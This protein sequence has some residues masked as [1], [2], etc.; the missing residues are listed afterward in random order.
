VVDGTDTRVVQGWSRILAPGETV[1]VLVDVFA[2][3]ASVTNG[4]KALKQLADSDVTTLV[5]TG[6]TVGPLV[7]HDTTLVDTENIPGEPSNAIR[8]FTDGSFTTPTPWGVIGRNLFLR[9]DAAACDADPAVAE[10]RTVLI[11]GANGESEQATA[12]ETGPNTGIFVVAPLPIHAPPVVA[13]DGILE[14]NPND[15]FQVEL[16]G[17]GQTIATV[18]TLMN[19]ASV[20][21]DS[22][23]NDPIANATVRLVAATGGS[24]GTTAVSLP[25]GQSNPATTG[26]DGRFAFN[27]PAGDYCLVVVPP[28]GWAF[29]SKIAYTQLPAGRN[30]NVTGLTAGGSYGNS[31]HVG[32]DGTVVVDVPL[33]LTAQSGLFVQKD[34]SKATAEVGDFV[35]YTVGVRNG[36]GNALNRADVTLTDNFPA[37]FAYVAG[38]ARR[39]GAPLADPVKGAGA[40]ITFDIGHLDA[41]ALATITYRAR[42]APAA[43]KGDGTNRAQAFYTVAGVTTASNVAAAKVQ[44]EGGVFSDKGF[45]LGKIFLDCNANGLQDKGEEG[46]PGVRILLEDGTYAITDGEGKFSF[47]GIDARTHVVKAD[48]VTLPRGASLEVLSARNLGD[49]N[50]RIVD[51]KSGEM[52]R[53]DFAIAGCDEAVRGEV[54]GRRAAAAR[55]DDLAGLAGAQLTTERQVITDVKALPASGVVERTPAAT[56]PGAAPNA[57]PGVTAPYLSVAPASRIGDTLPTPAP[58][59]PVSRSTPPPAEPLE[60]LVEGFAD[61]HLA[62]VG[63]ED[64][65]TLA[66]AQSNIRV[67]GTAGTTFRLVVNDEA[68]PGSAVGKR[69]VLAAK[70]V[71]AW[72]FVGIDLRAGDNTIT[73]VQI[74]SFGNERGTATIHVK[75]PGH[76]GKIAIDVPAA[77]AIADGKTPVKVVVR[78]ADENGVPVTVR[79]PVTLESARGRWLSQDLDTKAPGLQQFIENGRGEFE[80]VPTLEPGENMVY[81]SSGRLKAQARLDFLPEMRDMVATGVIE[82]IINAR[83]IN[84]RALQPATASDAFEQELRHLSRE[85]NAGKADGGVR[86]AF[87]LK[88]KIKGDYLLTAAYDSDKDTRERLFRDIQPDEFYPVYGDSAVR[89]FDAQSTSKLYVRVDKGRSYLLWGDFSTTAASETRKL[90]NYTRS[91]TGLKEHYENSRLSVNAFASRDTTRQVIE[92]QRANGTS[93]PFQLS[94]SGS[95]VNSETI[96]VV[97][98]DRN[99]PAIII[100]TV[101][102]ARFVDYEVEALT[103]RILFKAPIASVDKDLNPNF[104]RITYEVDQGGPEFWVAG[105]D[106][107]VKVSDRIEVGGIFVKDKNPLQPFTLGG[108]NMVVKLGAATY[109]ISEVA[110]SKSGLDDITGNAGRIEVKHESKDL[111]AN[112]F[113]AHTDRGFENPGS[114]LIE[115]R[116]EAGGKVDYKISERLTLHAE[117]LRTQDVQSGSRRDGATAGLQIKLAEHLTL[118]VGM[119]HSAEK[120]DVSPIPA[121]PG[122]PAPLPMPDEVTTARARLTGDIPGVKKATAYG[123]AEVDVQDASRKILAVGGEYPLFDKG[124]IYARHEFIS[125]ITGPYGLNPNERQNTTAVGIDTEYMKDGRFYSEYRIADAMSGGDT[126][127]ALGLKNL[128]S[129][130][131]GLKL[132]TTFERVHTL[133]GTGVDENTALALALEYTA[134]PNWK[135]STRLELRNASSQDSLLFTVGMAA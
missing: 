24:C 129:I 1:R 110:R 14:G 46:V 54:A 121:L 133:A 106:A 48:R 115:G 38:S 125:S 34:A 28:N 72:E 84:T 101:P 130:A 61:N 83:N 37:G 95:L 33:D 42:I 9:A 3:S 65:Q 21:F 93:G 98:R 82:G 74:D 11:T 126:E 120:G 13:G 7:V 107:Q 114:Y 10:S 134:N 50:S 39:D 99:Q 77:G 69:S 26:A 117:A 64:G 18:V 52:A 135:G 109:V 75:A 20:V 67:K 132:G 113:V 58:V 103:G 66:F 35:D 27:A 91:L 119:R 90:T 8:N 49:P 124:R 131:P 80:L 57:G 76:L 68:V 104:I 81:A 123:E 5:I 118:E 73:A 56:M 6:V 25:A 62:F 12:V 47:Y 2:P 96:E 44:I 36:T 71:Q 60:A 19:A 88:G 105:V 23:S 53:A 31:F 128:W 43:L 41:G 97:T 92:E 16:Q 86:A 4:T 17:C 116:S 40:S 85:W 70:E 78:I 30:L 32:A 108:A 45:I 87:Y 59:L 55:A 89:G 63:M 29:P 79:T 100:A 127:A 51:L 15:V 122:Q 94:T 102:L 112:A 22:R 111:K